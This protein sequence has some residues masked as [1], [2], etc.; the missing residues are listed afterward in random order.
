MKNKSP[1]F[2][3][4]LTGHI[5]TGKSK[6]VVVVVVK[7]LVVKGTDEQ[8]KN[9]ER[10]KRNFLKKHFKSS[11][12]AFDFDLSRLKIVSIKVLESLGYGTPV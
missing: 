3:V 4:T 8:I 12:K 5:T 10:V 7:E 6:K 11:K 9:S 1:I 2:Y